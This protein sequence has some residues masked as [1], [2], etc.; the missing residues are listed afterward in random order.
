MAVRGR[1]LALAGIKE[2]LS[3][4]QLLGGEEVPCLDSEEARLLSLKEELAASKGDFG[5]ILAALRSEC[6]LTPCLDEH[7]GQFLD[8]ERGEGD[9]V[10]SSDEVE[11]EG[12]APRSA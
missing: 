10:P 5:S 3:K 2:S 6:I 12:G 9:A 7:E 8:I 1:D 11:D 4:I